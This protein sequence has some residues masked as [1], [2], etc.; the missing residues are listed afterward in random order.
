MEEA[1]SGGVA[2]PKG[3]IG[4]LA[5]IALLVWLVFETVPPKLR[6]L[7][8]IAFFLVFLVAGIVFVVFGKRTPPDDP[9]GSVG[10]LL[11]EGEDNGRASLGPSRPIEPR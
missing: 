11:E 4:V 8:L 5:A 2:V 7:V 9:E 1:D 6:D 10:R 3:S